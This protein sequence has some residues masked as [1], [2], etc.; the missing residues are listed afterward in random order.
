MPI[1]LLPLRQAVSTVIREEV[2]AFKRERILEEAARQFYDKGYDGARVDRIASA[3]GVTKPYIYYHFSNKTELLDEICVRATR[4]STEALE[5]ALAESEDLRERL[6]RAVRLLALWAM[7]HQ[8]W[9]AICFREEKYLS[10]QARKNI[11]Q[12]RRKFDRQLTALLRDGIDE[13][14]LH[15]TDPAVA[16]QA[17]TGLITWVFVWYRP[18]GRLSRDALAEQLVQLSLNMLGARDR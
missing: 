18:G 12:Y 9:I 17:L 6:K 7:E 5:R 11:E 8:S 13:R 14:T 4:Y 15:V 3:L 10:P 16:A 2:N 1:N